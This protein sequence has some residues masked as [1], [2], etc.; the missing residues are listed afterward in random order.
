MGL[1]SLIPPCIKNHIKLIQM[2]RRYPGRVIESHMIAENAQIGLN[3]LVGQDVEINEHV[4]LGDYSTV[5][6]GVVLGD[7][8]YIGAYSYINAFSL[9]ASGRTEYANVKSKVAD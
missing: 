3:C 7:A 2:K 9:I 4:Y 8:V 5:Y 6:R 1:K